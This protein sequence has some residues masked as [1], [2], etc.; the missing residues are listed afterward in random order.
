MRDLWF[1]TDKESGEQVRTARHG[2]GK[3]WL[4]RYRDE[5]G[6]DHTRAFVRKVDANNWLATE[7]AAM[8]KGEWV[9]PNAGKVTLARFYATWSPNQVWV[10]ST[11]DNADRTV[12][13]CT[14][15]DV[16][17]RSLRKSHVEAWVKGMTATL[18]ATTIDTR[19]TIIRGALR[20][21]VADRVIARDPSEGV[22][23]P[24]RRKAE[25]AMRLP[26]SEDVGLLLANAD[27]DKRVSTRHG[28]RAYVALC[29]FAGLRKGEAAAVQVGD[30]DFL[31]RTLR[32]TRQL[33]RDGQT[34]KVV[35]PKYGSER[36]VYLPD[37]LVAILSQHV[38]E[39]PPHEDGWLFTVG[40]GPLYD[41]AITWR[42]RATRDAADV[43]V[44]LHD[45]RHYF[46]SGLIAAGCD[47]VTVQRALGHAS[48]T[49]TLSTYAHLWPNA[50]DRTR[51]AAADLV[52]AALGEHVGNKAAN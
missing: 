23:L 42:W 34:F 1:T 48:A 7:T 10:D 51:T 41:N 28:F 37:G 2:V 15:K 14:F 5:T 52:A 27:Q 33:Q 49:T 46:A 50:E 4:G 40:N 22:A 13:T 12:D 21:A 31:R 16:P 44:R 20:A 25:A 8:V 3:R 47:V 43:D 38:A 26:S 18:A 36:T 45:L 11:R 9:D 32:V 24:R 17:L 39:H 35:P 19:M 29:A 6:R 30:I